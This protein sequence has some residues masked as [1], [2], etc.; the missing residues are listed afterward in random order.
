MGHCS[1]KLWGLLP[2]ANHPPPLVPPK[3]RSKDYE[4][5]VPFRNLTHSQNSN[6]R[7]LRVGPGAGTKLIDLLDFGSDIG[8]RTRTLR[9]ERAMKLPLHSV[10][11]ICTNDDITQ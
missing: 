8:A 4:R 5:P 10:A 7:T 6:L 9:L 1:L 11:H 2:T 3:C